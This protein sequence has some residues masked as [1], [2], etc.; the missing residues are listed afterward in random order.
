MVGSTAEAAVRAFARAY[1]SK[2]YASSSIKAAWTAAAPAARASASG[3]GKG[4]VL[5]KRIGSGG[6]GEEGRLPSSVTYVR[7]EEPS[8]LSLSMKSAPEGSR[9]RFT[10]T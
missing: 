9:S 1:C 5:L 8:S 6:N 2:A 3:G 4:R 10:D 7:T